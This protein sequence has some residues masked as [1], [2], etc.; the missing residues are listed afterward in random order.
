MTCIV[1]LVDGG[2]IY[3]GGDSA[4]I[5]GFDLR[6]RKDSKV[7]V[8][9]EMI[10]GFTSSFRMGQ[11]LRYNFSIPPHIPKKDD[12]T[13][14]CTDFIDSLIACFKEKGYARVNN[15]EITGGTFLVG[16]KSNLYRIDNDFQVGMTRDRYDACGCGENYALG[17]LRAM[18]G[19]IKDPKDIIMNAL[20][21]A[22]YFSCGVCTPF[23]IL[24]I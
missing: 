24:N 18:E 20:S 17:A 1:G 11:I 21:V 5:S 7:F 14:L 8:K 6:L 12:Y 3:I 15:Q 13:Y 9:D 4:G 22:E 2:E 10:F 19:K 16:Y 23:T